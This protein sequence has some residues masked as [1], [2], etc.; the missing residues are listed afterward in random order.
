MSIWQPNKRWCVWSEAKREDVFV[1]SETDCSLFLP[2]DEGGFYGI[3]SYFRMGPAAPRWQNVVPIYIDPKKRQRY[4]STS[5]SQDWIFCWNLQD[6]LRNSKC[7][8]SLLILGNRVCN[9]IYLLAHISWPYD[10][11][12]PHPAGSQLPIC[13]AFDWT[14][15]FLRSP[16]SWTNVILLYAKKI[17]QYSRTLWT[18]NLKKLVVFQAKTA[19]SDVRWI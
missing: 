1:P 19:F 10:C 5:A 2:V 13:S 12:W 18:S 14:N 4:I 7:Q 9:R 6:V 11:V 3:G 16:I 17:T 15:R 8:P